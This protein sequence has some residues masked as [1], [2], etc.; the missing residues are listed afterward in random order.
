MRSAAQLYSCGTEQLSFGVE[1]A[2]DGEYMNEGSCVE[3]TL[4]TKQR[5]GMSAEPELDHV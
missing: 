5:A 4:F 1:V 2:T 3:I